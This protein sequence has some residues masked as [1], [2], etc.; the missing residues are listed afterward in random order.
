MYHEL[1]SAHQCGSRSIHDMA[2]R[3][4]RQDVIRHMVEPFKAACVI[5]WPVAHSRSPMI[6]NHWISQ[7][8]LDA[9]YRREGVPPEQFADFVSHLAERGY[10]G[11]NVTV[12]HKEVA[13]RLADA[14][15]RAQAVGAANTLW[16]ER[17]V[18]K[19]T[20]TDVEGFIGNLDASAPGWD[21][22]LRTAVVL[23]AGGS[24]RAI[25]FGLIERGIARIYIANRSVERAKALRDQFGK[26]IDPRPFGEANQLLG[27]AGLLVNTTTL[28][29][30]GQPPLALDLDR[31]PA[32]A[33]VADIVYSPLETALL[34]AARQG[35]LRAVGG[36]GMLLHQAVGG[37]ERW[38][39]VRPQVTGELRALVEADLLPK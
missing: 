13:L 35:G 32:G 21:H 23:G 26:A 31:L 20:N 16:F 12:P 33:T 34:A 38:F 36:L 1:A 2:K 39:G 19:A 6:H 24:A 9:E 22:E 29:M 4:A 14:D 30:S 37:F 17:G 3:Q 5:G 11:A 18:L 27:E 15:A 8:G 10:V 25:V 28:G 7:L